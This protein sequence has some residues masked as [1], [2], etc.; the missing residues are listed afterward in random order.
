MA[1]AMVLLQAICD[2]TGEPVQQRL[3]EFEA[4]AARRHVFEA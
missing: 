1:M 3:E 2:A 4:A